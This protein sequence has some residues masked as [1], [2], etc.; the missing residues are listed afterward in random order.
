MTT[1][2]CPAYRF[3]VRQIAADILE[4]A[5]DEAQEIRA[6]YDRWLEAR[7]A[8]VSIEINGLLQDRQ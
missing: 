5:D 7:L 6:H 4:V 3:T 1:I 8:E 2:L